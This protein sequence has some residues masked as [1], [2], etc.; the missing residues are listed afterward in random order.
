MKFPFGNILIVEIILLGFWP[1]S[2]HQTKSW[3]L[4]LSKGFYYFY[5]GLNI[6]EEKSHFLFAANDLFLSPF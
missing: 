4:L 3:I 1:P 6:L 5:C 2:L